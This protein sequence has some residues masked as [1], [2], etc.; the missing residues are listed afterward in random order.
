MIPA[1][2][3]KKSAAFTLASLGN[4]MTGAPP[5]A[6][7]GSSATPVDTASASDAG[8]VLAAVGSDAGE[9]DC[10]ES[11]CETVTVEAVDDDVGSSAAHAAMASTAL[12]HESTPTSRT[13]VSCR[14]IIAPVAG[15]VLVGTTLAI[16][17]SRERVT[18]VAKA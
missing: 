4:R 14:R 11:D 2:G 7:V 8:P 1:P 15:L 18:H 9:S 3:P 6:G 5:V 17:T 12:A 13:I 16:D 10:G